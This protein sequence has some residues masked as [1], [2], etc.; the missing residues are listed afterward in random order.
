MGR[1][2]IDRP[3]KPG[4]AHSGRR[5][6]GWN[7]AMGLFL[8]GTGQGRWTVTSEMKWPRLR[9][10]HKPWMNAPRRAWSRERLRVESPHPPCPV[11]V[12]W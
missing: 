3:N 11:T 6:R 10:P 2:S 12:L 9:Q 7:P 1:V 4:G 5:E 8:I